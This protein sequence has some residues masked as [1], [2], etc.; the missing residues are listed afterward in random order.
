MK[1]SNRLETIISFVAKGSHVADIGSD[2]GHVII[3]LVNRHIALSC[4]G[5]EN[6]EGPFKILQKNTKNIA[7]IEISFS[8]GLEKVPEYYSTGIIAGMGFATIKDIIEKSMDKL[9]FI[10]D[11]IIDSHTLTYELRKY[12]CSLGYYIAEEKCLF[13][14][15]VFYEIEHFKKGS[16][17]YTED[18]YFFGPLIRLNRDDQFIEHIKS[19]IF[20]YQKIV[21]SHKISPLRK[22]EI[23]SKIQKLIGELNEN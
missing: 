9:S 11:L 6:K 3:E 14:K 23:A 18:D 1:L 10:D 4:F 2:H 19:E 5:V 16:K 7:N 17:Q 8:D 13:D 15:G 20:N 22:K 12:I 21:L